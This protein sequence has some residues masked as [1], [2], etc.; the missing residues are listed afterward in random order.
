MDGFVGR[1]SD[2]SRLRAMFD[3]PDINAIA[4][5]GIRRVGKTELIKRFTEGMD[6]LY[7]Q[8][9]RGPEAMVIKGAMGQIP[10]DHDGST[11]LDMIESITELC[12]EAPKVVVMDEVQYLLESVNGSDTVLQRFIDNVLRETGSRLILCGSKVSML[13]DTVYKERNPLYGRLVGMEV[14]PMTFS[15][16]CLFHTQ[17]SDRDQ[18]RMYMLF[19][20]MPWPHRVSKGNS[21][22]EVVTTWYLDNSSPF[23]ELAAGRI[24]NELEHGDLNEVIVRAVAGGA[25]SLKDIAFASGLSEPLCK[26]YLSRLMD[27]GI[28]GTY[29]PMFGAPKRKF[30]R[31][32]DGQADM[33]YSL[34]DRRPLAGM[35]DDPGKRYALLE[36]RIDTLM[37]HRFEL[38]CSEW[39]SRNYMCQQIGRWWGREETEDGSTETDIDI[40]AIVDTGR[41]RHSLF[42][43]CKFRDS[44]ARSADLRALQRRAGRLTPTPKLMIISAGGF[45]QDLADEAEA[46]GAVLVGADELMG[47]IP[48]PSLD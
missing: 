5:Y 42:V 25:H 26:I 22:R 28:L 40:T 9:D 43:E 46:V 24:R 7:I 12:R 41:S 31:I 37:G 29:T 1:S 34:F 10:V 44:P 18:M 32:V 21:F 13:K 19:G 33:W 14:E 3:N 30:Y 27:V 47:R 45:E 8:F 17:M 36:K 23:R 6:V 15:D 2:L 16:T 4:V 20:G 48:A 39:I 38:F 35:P 11:I